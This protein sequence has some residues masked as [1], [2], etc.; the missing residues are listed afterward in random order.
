MLHW[1]SEDM[2]ESTL[3]QRTQLEELAPKDKKDGKKMGTDNG[4]LPGLFHLPASFTP[5]PSLYMNCA[6]S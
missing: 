2:G 6:Q 1:E 4:V 3:P 5:L